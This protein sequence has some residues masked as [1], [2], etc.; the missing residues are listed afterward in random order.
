MAKEIKFPYLSIHNVQAKVE[1]VLNTHDKRV[2]QRKYDL[3]KETFDITKGNSEGF[4][5][6]DRLYSLQVKSKEQVGYSTC[7]AA[8]SITIRP[9]KRINVSLMPT[10]TRATP[11]S[12]SSSEADTKSEY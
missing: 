4:C 10:S 7:K 1:N 11:V 2:K 3:L 8:S 5:S 12:S 6:E 9:S